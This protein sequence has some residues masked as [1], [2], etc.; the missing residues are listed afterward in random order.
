[1][2]HPIDYQLSDLELANLSKVFANPANLSILT[3]LSTNQQ[4]YKPEELI[5]PSLNQKQLSKHLAALRKT[6]L[7]QFK[8]EGKETYY[9]IHAEQFEKVCQRFINFFNEMSGLN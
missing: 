6:E 5:L 8:I 4:W 9:S 2:N 1:M 3:I 7:I